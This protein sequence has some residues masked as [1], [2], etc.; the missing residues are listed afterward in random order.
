MLKYRPFV[1]FDGV[2]M[3]KTKY[4]RNGISETS[5]YHPIHEV[6]SYRYIRFMKNG[7]TMSVYTV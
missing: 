2:Y 7:D 3:C 4:F 1:R 6:I 5:Q